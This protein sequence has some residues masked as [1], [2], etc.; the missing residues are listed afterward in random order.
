MPAKGDTKLTPEAQETVI[1]MFK[2]GVCVETAM[3]AINCGHRTYYEWIH[4][5]RAEDADEPYKTFAVLAEAARAEAHDGAE[6]LYLEM[7]EEQAREGN[8]QPLKAYLSAHLPKTWGNKMTMEADVKAEVESKAEVE[9]RFTSEELSS[10][11]QQRI[12]EQRRRYANEQAEEND[13]ADE[14]EAE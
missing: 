9:H 2:R 10:M 5:G 1:A 8:L 11:A 3:R 4:R 6:A 13:Q 7:A 12:K 14:E